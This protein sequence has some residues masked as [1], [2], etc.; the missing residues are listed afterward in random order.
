MKSL[1]SLT[2]AISLAIL[3]ATSLPIFAQTKRYPTDIELQELNKQFRRFAASPP[4]DE[5]RGAYTRDRRDRESIQQLNFFVKAW[6]QIEPQA[7]PFFGYWAGLEETKSIYPSTVK[8]RVCII[9][10]FYPPTPNQGIGISFSQATLYKGKIKT[11][12]PSILFAQGNYLGVAFIDTKNQPGI[13]EYAWPKPLTNPDELMRFNP[14]SERNRL[15]QQFKTAGC[16]YS[17]PNKR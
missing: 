11:T 9:D 13:Y 4:R 17:L 5:Y 12:D 10:T 8:G 6:S 14:A 2:I 7:A 3:S 16:T 15:L 1:A